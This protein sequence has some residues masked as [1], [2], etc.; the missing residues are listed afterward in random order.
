MALGGI[1][2]LAPGWRL[3]RLLGLLRRGS[4]LLWWGAALLGWGA[5]QLWGSTLLLLLLRHTGLDVHCKQKDTEV[6][7]AG[8]LE[9]L[10]LG[11]PPALFTPTPL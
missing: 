5:A 9:G 4:A 8:A 2:L 10:F 1:G 7:K 6:R 3:A 11:E